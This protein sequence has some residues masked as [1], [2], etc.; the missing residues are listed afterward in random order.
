MGAQ[1]GREVERREDAGRRGLGF[2]AAAA[3]PAVVDHLAGFGAIAQAF[4]GDGWMEHVAGQAPTGIVIFGSNRLALE[5]REARMGP[6]LDDFDPVARN[7]SQ[8]RNC[9]TTCRTT[10]RQNPYSRS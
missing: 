4:E 2:A 8:S 3:L 6:V 7:F 1:G 5:N 10:G 9:S